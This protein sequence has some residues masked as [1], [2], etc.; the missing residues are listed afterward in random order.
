MP[1]NLY[2]ENDNFHED[3]NINVIFRI[4]SGD[5]RNKDG[6][7]IVNTLKKVKQD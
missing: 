1:T 4:Y 5:P 6:K 2:G 7:D 3:S